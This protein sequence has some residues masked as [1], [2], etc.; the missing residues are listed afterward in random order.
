MFSVQVSGSP[1]NIVLSNNKVNNKINCLQ[2][3]QTWPST[4]VKI[5]SYRSR[6][7]FNVLFSEV[8]DTENWQKKNPSLQVWDS[9]LGSLFSFPG[10]Q[11]S[12]KNN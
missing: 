11:L 1:N 6:T 7:D 8:V 5:Q 10:K 2:R 12:E 3:V 4:T 9:S